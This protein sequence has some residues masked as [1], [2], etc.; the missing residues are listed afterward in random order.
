MLR[1]PVA[2]CVAMSCLAAAPDV[3]DDFYKAI[4]ADDSAAVTKLLQSGA[5]VNGKDNRGDTPLM[6][7]AAVGSENMMRQLIEAGADVNARN[8]FQATALLWC[9]SSLPRVRLLVE[10]GADVNVRSKQGHTPV[11]V[12]A[13]H[14]GS[15]EILK[16]LISMGASLKVP[17]DTKGGTP[18]TYAADVNDTAAVKF[19]LEKGGA[20]AL[21]GPAAPMALMSAAGHGNAELVKLLLAKGAPVNAQSPAE[22]DGRV[23]N[24]PIALGSFTALIL[25]VAPGD[26]ETVRLLLES[27]ADVNAQD[28]R[29]MTPLMLAVATDHPNREVIRMLLERHPDTKI[30]SKA[31]E[32]ALDWA[33]K[34]KDQSII[35]A[36]R[37]ASPGVTTAETKPPALRF[38]SANDA[39]AALQKS[40]GLIQTAGATTFREGGCVSCHGGN[41]TMAAVAAARAKGIRVDEAAAAEYVRATRLQYAAFADLML[42]RTDS[43]TPLIE[44][45]ALFALAQEGVPAD[46]IIDALVSTV[47][48]RQLPG[49][50]WIYRSIMRP[51]TSDSPF[52]TT[53]VA[54][55]ALREYAPPARK[56]EFDERI[57]RAVRA[58][59]SA[60]P[61]TTE[62]HV[63]Q[64]LGLRWAG[65]D[66]AKIVKAAKAV[67]ALQREDGGWAQ[68]PLL[69]SDAYATGT[70]LH[71]LY[72]TGMRAD[73]PAYR[74]GVA[75]LLRTQAADGSWHVA[76]R[77]P[78]FQPYFEGGFPYGHD[79]WISQWG[80]GWAAV[81]LAHALPDRRAAVQAK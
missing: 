58:L 26:T 57:A 64:L 48:A 81:A 75:F 70:A 50:Y 79:Q 77:A 40:I 68:T 51:P 28:V 61:T 52:T 16:L 19:L 78:K 66:A 9:S 43:P 60:E 53:A 6:Y 56:A 71:A 80:T 33:L 38:A 1:F 74:K 63:M 7:A 30:K 73:S 39:R 55:R 34:F 12:A 11:E 65:A 13:H 3:S 23:K 45:N 49:G 41:I 29:G 18:L 67:A 14:A 35:A 31:G 4:R 42:E 59:E 27:A 10:H 44:S 46:R 22:V 54:I 24:G 69:S 47:A 32:T 62:D 2:V 17:P 5:D 21:A 72:E 20:D 37:A 36:V 25:A 15:L 8:R 76:S